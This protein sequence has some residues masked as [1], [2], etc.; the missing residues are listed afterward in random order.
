MKILIV[1]W[2]IFYIDILLGV[3]SYF[4]EYKFYF[5]KVLLLNLRK[6]YSFEN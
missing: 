2:V 1:N 6:T 3:L 5:K 4:N